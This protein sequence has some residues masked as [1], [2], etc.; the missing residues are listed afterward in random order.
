MLG[1]STIRAAK[2]LYNTGLMRLEYDSGMARHTE[3]ECAFCA[4]ELDPE[5]S[6]TGEDWK[7][8]CSRECAE[9]GALIE[10]EVREASGNHIEERRSD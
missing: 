4:E 7:V 5:N 10:A 9:A 1:K 2:L 6:Y 8:Y 3:N